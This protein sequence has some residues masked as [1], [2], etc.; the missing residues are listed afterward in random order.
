[1]KEYKISITDFEVWFNGEQEC[2]SLPIFVLADGTNKKW[3]NVDA[4]KEFIENSVESYPAVG[5]QPHKCSYREDS[6]VCEI[7]GS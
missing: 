3:I 2:F 5:E 6:T 1:M 7:C 4:L